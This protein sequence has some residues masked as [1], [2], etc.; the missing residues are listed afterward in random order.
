MKL[1]LRHS[2]LFILLLLSGL[3]ISCVESINEIVDGVP[4][5]EVYSPETGDTV[6][7]GKNKIFYEAYDA[8]GY[9]D[10][11]SHFEVFVNGESNGIY[12][13]DHDTSITPI[14][15]NITE[16][17]PI[18]SKISY[19]VIVY[20][21]R[22]PIT[23]SPVFEDVIVDLSPAPPDEL[24]LQWQNEQGTIVNLVWN[25]NATNE[26]SYE[27][28]RKDGK[29]GEYNLLKTLNANSISTNDNGLLTYVN[30][31]YKVRAVNSYGK[32]RFSNEVN[33]KG[34]AGGDAPSDLS[35]EPLGASSILLT[36]TD[37]SDSEMG[38][39]V[40]KLNTNNGEW[41]KLTL[42]PNNTTEYTDQNLV[43]G[44]TY[45]YRVAA[46]FSD[47]QSAYSNE[48]EATTAWSDVPEPKDLRASY[49]SQK[50]HVVL[51]WKDN[52]NQEIGTYIE[53]R[54]GGSGQFI[55]I[56]SVGTD[57]TEFIDS[58]ISAKVTYY[59]RARHYAVAGHYTQYSNYAEVFIPELPP[60]APTNL[61][62]NEFETGK[63]YGLTW[64]DNSSDE[65]GFELQRK[66]GDNGEFETYKIFA[67]N[68]KA[69]NDSIQ[70]SSVTYYYRVRAFRNNLVSDFTNTVS[71]TG[72]AID[73]LGK[74]T[75]LV[76]VYREGS[77][78]IIDLSWNDNS[79]KEY[80]FIIERKEY[81]N[82]QNNEFVEIK[83][84]G[85]N[86][87]NYADDDP[88]LA[89]GTQYIYRIKAYN[90]Q[91]NSEYSNE[92]LVEIPYN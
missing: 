50:S 8:D 27:L 88:N 92:A 83:T 36:W 66:A 82:W 77:T 85:P 43:K 26:T 72:S 32:S 38:F 74:P 6:Q 25:D 61:K 55:E 53:R 2:R 78:Y 49:N 39:F 7:I 3:L 29:N 64:Q 4:T 34:V 69:Y 35:A 22:N 56:G 23:K 46:Y 63:L 41:D 48:A 70:N 37:N 16:D 75:N 12:D 31:Y 84:L 18:E 52:T 33:S 21:K 13:H 90:A 60:T 11:L 45:R 89:R 47:S 67:P 71:T 15:M 68:T 44:N 80:G 20:D 62:I 79:T 91:D 59:Y 57:Q 14:Y 73:D 1:K 17:M 81:E 40:E 5:I 19:Y 28:W 42:L 58:T 86:S 76:A 30:Y 54:E 10:N 9:K 51:T 24:L 65:D 87:E